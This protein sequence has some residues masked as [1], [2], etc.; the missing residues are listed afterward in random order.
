M[1]VAASPWPRTGHLLKTVGGALYKGF[2]GSDDL[3]QCA[4]CPCGDDLLTSAV[5]PREATYPTMA[6]TLPANWVIL[7]TEG[8]SDLSYVW[9]MDHES[10]EVQAYVLVDTTG[11]AQGVTMCRNQTT[12]IFV[13]ETGSIYKVGIDGADLKQVIDYCDEF[14]ATECRGYGLANWDHNEMLYWVD[15]ELGALLAC[16]YDGST[17]ETLVSGVTDPYGVSIDQKSGTVYFTA[18]G[19]LYRTAH[20]SFDLTLSDV[21]TFADL[22]YSITNVGIDSELRSV[23]WTG[24]SSVFRASITPALT[25]VHTVYEG[26]EGAN[27]VSVDWASNLLFFTDN[28]GVH[29]GNL[30]GSA[31]TTMLAYLLNTTFVYVKHEAT[32]TPAPTPIPSALPTSF[33]SSTPTALPTALP[34]TIPT[35]V[36]TTRPSPVPTSTPSSE[37]TSVPTSKPTSHPSPSKFTLQRRLDSPQVP[38]LRRPACPRAHQPRLPVPS[39]PTCPRPRRPHCRHPPR[40][41]IISMTALDSTCCS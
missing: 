36:P 40:G 8:Q 10:A 1:A 39:R 20:N 32:P 6:P 15:A 31:E 37:P 34:S 17:L 26:F 2:G 9:I 38:R 24:S 12:V 41:A 4:D 33:P 5:V 21:D 14:N 18:D 25:T 29:L 30:D 7:W 16:S 19:V 35:S 13:D 22:S 3:A 27:S 11:K 23:Y 28:D